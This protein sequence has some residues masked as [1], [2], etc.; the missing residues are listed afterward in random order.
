MR[1]ESEVIEA[2]LAF[3]CQ[4][5]R[6]RAAVLNGSRANP[7]IS[8]DIFCDYDIALFVIDPDDFL[9]DQSWI[10]QFGDRI[11]VQQNAWQEGEVTAYV[12]L[13]L[14][15]DGV[16]I[17]LAFDPIEHIDM[18]LEDSLTVVLL[19]KDQVIP[20][21]PPPSERSYFTKKPTQ[22][23]FDEIANEFWWCSTNVAKGIWRREL[24]Y[25]K[26]MYEVI[27]RE[28]ILKMLSWY[29]G[30][31]HDWQVNPGD[32][33][34][35]FRRY[36]PAELWASFERTYAGYEQAGMWAALFEAGGLIRVIGPEIAQHLG[37]TY[38]FQDDARVTAYLQ[39]VSTLPRDADSYD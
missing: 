38:P 11:I 29:I 4:D 19:D 14:F 35:W 2:V 1:R 33:G 21:L 16:R 23:E 30:M 22:Q 9:H 7:N 26:W 36:L 15:A 24:S 27:V 39:R 6:I 5:D 34:K 3:A 37:Y 12:F 32:Y 31:H 18:F 28:C 25:A 13:M 8:K 17:D 10:Q 20:T